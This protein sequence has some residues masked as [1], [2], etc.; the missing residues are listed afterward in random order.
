MAVS[1][2][3]KRIPPVAIAQFF[4]EKSKLLKSLLKMRPLENM[5]IYPFLVIA[6]YIEEGVEA[7]ITI[8]F[9]VDAEPSL[10]YFCVTI[11]ANVDGTLIN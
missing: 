4:L 1:E 5:P 3:P 2:D 10:Q 11:E 6:V 9:M 7:D 8:I